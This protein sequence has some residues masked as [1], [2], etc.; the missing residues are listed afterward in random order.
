MRPWTPLAPSRHQN[1]L[2]Y[3]VITCF[4]TRRHWTH[5][6]SAQLVEEDTSKK[7]KAESE[8][9]SS[10]TVVGPEPKKL[11]ASNGNA[12]TSTEIEVSVGPSLQTTKVKAVPLLVSSLSVPVGNMLIYVPRL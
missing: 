10:S 11:K 7:R 4:R 3:Q 5:F 1:R 12:S 6:L 2:N 8:F 9:L